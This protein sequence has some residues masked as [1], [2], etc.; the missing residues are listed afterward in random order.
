MYIAEETR[1]VEKRIYSR[2][3]TELKNYFRQ[4]SKKEVIEQFKQYLQNYRVIPVVLKYFIRKL[5]INH[6]HRYVGH[7][8]DENLKKH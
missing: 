2:K 7:L 6:F 8:D 4:N 1:L 3:C 5:I